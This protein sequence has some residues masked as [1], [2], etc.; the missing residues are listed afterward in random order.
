MT[1]NKF[2][3]FGIALAWPEFYCKQSCSWYD[4]YTDKLGISKNNFYKVGHAAVLLVDIKNTECKYFDFGRY[5]APF[6]YGRARGEETDHELK[7]YTKPIF[8][9]DFSTI[10]NYK[11][12]LSD[13]QN[14]EGCHGEGNLYSSYTKINFEKAY[15]K[16]KEI[17][18]ASP[19]AYGP[20]VYKGTNCSR[21]VNTVIRAG[22]PKFWD[23]FKLYF[24]LPLTPTPRTNIK[25]LS[26]RKITPKLIPIPTPEPPKLSKNVLFS[27]LSE[28]PKH[29]IIPQNAKWLSGEGSGS[30]FALSFE[31]ELLK[32]DRYSVK[33]EIECSGLFKPD[34]VVDFKLTDDFKLGY[35]STCKS[36]KILYNNKEYVFRRI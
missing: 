11:E 19:V 30:W 24:F 33:G 36:V 12:L 13:L 10:L 31:N 1:D 20:F 6:Q 7:F 18:D 4:V 5:H 22:E 28:P 8:S 17:Q 23:W 34:S 14:N 21:F 15:K 9:K 2:T 3:G 16:A 29:E 26:H 27:I 32:S 25:A 35:P